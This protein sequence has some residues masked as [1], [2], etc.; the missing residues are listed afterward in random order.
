MIALK[1][2]RGAATVRDTTE[3]AT[4]V[5]RQAWL[6]WA[7]EQLRA[8]FAGAGHSAPENVRV[9]IGWPRSARGNAIGQCWYPEASTDAAHEV[10]VSPALS[11][12]LAI[13]ATL[14][15]EL[16]HTVAGRKAGH[17]P[18]FKRIAVAVG[19]EGR[20]TA[21]VPGDAFKRYSEGVFQAI[22]HYPAGA[23]ATHSRVK[24]GTRLL[25]VQC[26]SCGYTARVTAK[27][28]ADAGAPLCPCSRE[29]MGVA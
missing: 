19:L 18:L 24:Q 23:L 5:A 10:F 21:T 8:R 17:G 4:S 28:I 27:W 3:C 14:A 26:D 29:P 1:A 22:G 13:L 9:S 12:S 11:D 2:Q 20:M 6:E 25:K 7:T 15:H 16:A